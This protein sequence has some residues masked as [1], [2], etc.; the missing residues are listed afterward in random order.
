MK[1]MLA[2]VVWSQMRV[3]LDV[4]IIG[5][6]VASLPCI[7]GGPWY[8]FV[9]TFVHLLFEYKRSD[10]LLCHSNEFS[11]QI[12]PSLSFRR[13]RGQPAA[14]VPGSSLPW[15]RVWLMLPM[16]VAP[17]GSAMAHGTIGQKA[18]KELWIT[19]EMVF[20]FLKATLHWCLFF[21]PTVIYFQT[22]YSAPQSDL[23]GR[24]FWGNVFNC[25]MSFDELI[26]EMQLEKIICML[27]HM[28]KT[29]YLGCSK[30]WEKAREIAQAIK[31][32]WAQYHSPYKRETGVL[33]HL[34][35]LNRGVWLTGLQG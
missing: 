7:R 3:V 22:V 18:E 6:R 15:P 10:L 34:N 5:A 20:F 8:S 23:S 1:T 25:V 11:S 14:P 9:L 19:G 12:A 32:T 33:A 4:S 26:Q 2:N 35:S 31:R 28:W 21:F 29:G 13:E 16:I 30:T 27:L 17:A 24:T